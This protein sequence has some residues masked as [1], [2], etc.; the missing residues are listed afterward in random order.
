VQGNFPK[1]IPH[2]F[3]PIKG[4]EHQ[5]DFVPCNS[6]PNHPSYR[7]NLKELNEIQ[8]Q[9]TQFLNKVLVSESMSLYA[10]SIILV[11]K[12][13]GTWYLTTRYRYLIP[14]LDDLLDELHG[15]YVF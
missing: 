9:V 3:P 12:K 8:E 5:I 14:C 2:G 7:E 10:I 15:L 4:S 6:L 11:L 13:D 1:K